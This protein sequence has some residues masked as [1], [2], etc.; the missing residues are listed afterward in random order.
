MKETVLV[1]GASGFVGKVVCQDL[2][3]RGYR[4]RAAARSEQGLPPG[5]EH[6]PL[7]DLTDGRTDWAPLVRDVHAVVYLAARVHVMNDTHPDP[8]AAYRAVNRDA[9]LGLAAAAAQAGVRRFAYLSSIKVNGEATELGQPFT[10][11]SIPAPTDPY[12]ISKYEA[13]QALL[14]FGQRTALEVVVLRPPLVYGPGVKANFMAL[15]RLAGRGWPLPLGAVQNRRSLIYV[16]NLAD[17]IA[18]VLDHPAAAGQVFLASDGEDLS[19]ADLT[20]HLAEAQGRRAWLIAVPTHWLWM[21]GRMTGRSNVMSRL[22]GSLEV[23]SAKAQEQLNWTPPYPVWQALAR[24]G[25]RL[26]HL[27]LERPLR[28][29]GRQR[30]YLWLRTPLERG[31]ALLLLLALSPLILVLGLLI[32]LD[33]PGPVLFKQQRAGRDHVPFTIYKFR[34]MRVGTPNL[35]TEDMVKSGMNPITR[36]GAVLRR[37]SLDE[38]PQLLNV[39]RGD[40]SLIGPRPALL[41]QTPV[42]NLRAASGVD[43]LRPGITGYAQV[44][45]RD[46]LPDEE[47]VERDTA[48]LQNL[49]PGMDLTV[50]RLTIRSVLHGTGNK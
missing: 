42:L 28:L 15:A 30:L 26:R 27:P 5:S 35:S 34:T 50:A 37:T 1:V 6:V 22:L 11:Q 2:L 14:S 18:L 10:E 21:L 23:S 43:R 19:S 20:R 7:P 39:L 17:L 16:E 46:D 3:R 40:M 12:G 45:G 8:L 47:K 48:Y 44:T 9:P 13:E 25:Q 4:V 31:A 38:L 41:T 36:L 32:R 33:S 29:K 24:T 49:S